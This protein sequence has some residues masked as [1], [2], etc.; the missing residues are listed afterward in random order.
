V[1]ETSHA[2]DATGD[3]WILTGPLTMDSAASVLS[4]SRDMRLPSSGIVDLGRLD[5]VDSA[6][7]AVLIAWKRRAK[8]EGAPMAFLNIPPTMASLANLY[9][10]EELLQAAIV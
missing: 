4:S 9:G 7:V 1:N 2:I 3:R 10:V 5:A 8:A 6:A